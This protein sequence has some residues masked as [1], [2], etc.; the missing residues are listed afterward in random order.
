MKTDSILGAISR[1]D[2]LCSNRQGHTSVN[3][4]SGIS[5]RSRYYLLG[6]ESELYL[7]IALRLNASCE[8]G[9]HHRWNL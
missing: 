5:L 7:K 9:K 8:V 4:I 1:S 2:T 6:R 3:A